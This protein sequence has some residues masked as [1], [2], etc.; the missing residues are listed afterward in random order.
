MAVSVQQASVGSPA[1]VVTQFYTLLAAAGWTVSGSTVAGAGGG[2]TFALTT[3]SGVVSDG[4]QGWFLTNSIGQTASISQRRTTGS[5]NTSPQTYDPPT[6][7]WIFSDP[8]PGDGNAWAAGVIAFGYNA[9]RHFYFGYVGGRIGGFTGGEIVAGSH[10]PVSADSNGVIGANDV[11]SMQRLFGGACL[12]GAANSGSI[13]VVHSANPN[14]M[15]FFGGAWASSGNPPSTFFTSQN[16]AFGGIGDEVN[17]G[18]LDRSPS[19]FA[20]GFSLVPLNLYIDGPGGYFQPIGY[21]PGVR[22]VLMIDPL[23]EQVLTIASKQ[24]QVF[25]LFKKCATQAQPGGSGWHEESSWYYGLAYE[26]T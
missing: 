3:G 20:G 8:A 24:W 10:C 6:K 18:Y 14:P 25:P 19:M 26:A 15:R 21:P 12:Y 11:N 17:D 7:L 5:P 9:Y 1:D 4:N 23:P 2:T 16:R 22:A 13:H